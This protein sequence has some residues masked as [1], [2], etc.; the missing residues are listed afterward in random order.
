MEAERGEGEGLESHY[1]KD[2]TNSPILAIENISRHARL[3]N[4][5]QRY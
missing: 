5:K 2:E 3:K 1:Y 4:H